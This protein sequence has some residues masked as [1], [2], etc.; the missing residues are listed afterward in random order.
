MSFKKELGYFFKDLIKGP[1]LSFKY[2][3]ITSLLF[4]FSL[5]VF[6]G[7]AFYRFS[8]G[9]G[10]TG[11]NDN[12]AWGI[13][14][15]LKLSLVVFSGCAFTL[16]CMVYVF[17]M[18]RFRPLVRSAAFIGFLGYATFALTLIFELGWPWRI[19]HPIWMHNYHSIL[20]EIAWCVMLYLTVLSLEF[21][22][23]ILERFKMSKI[24]KVFKTLTPSF[25]IAGIILSVLHQSSLG[26]LF[27]MAPYKMNHLWFSPWVGPFF[28]ISAVFCGL[29]MVIIVEL[30]MAKFDKRKPHKLLLADLG[31]YSIAALGLYLGFK[32]MDILERGTARKAFAAFDIYTLLF[33]IE[34]GIGIFLPIILFSRK[35]VRESTKGLGLTAALVLIFGGALNRLNVSVISLDHQ[36]L[37]YN[38][39]IIEYLYIPLILI[40]IS[41]VYII[42][43]RLFPI[44]GP[45]E[46][47]S[48]KY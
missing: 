12:T 40:L 30:F 41:C 24:L 32:V 29:S 20:F 13:W 7:L 39:T 28:I 27:V 21:I 48:E 15:V 6:L 3:L 22:P 34:I 18:E 42:A 5:I 45:V 11:L 33:I 31:K 9:L 1:V 19:V 36:P 23:N 47:L 38:P 35:K 25:V 46:S 4:T 43:T 17:K 14:T 16:T 44:Q 2:H 26:S 8:I 37:G 10:V